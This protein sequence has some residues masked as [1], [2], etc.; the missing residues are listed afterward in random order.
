MILFLQIL[1]GLAAVALGIY[2]GG[3]RYTQSQE[4]IEARM[5]V[6]KP[7]RAKRHFMWLDSLKAHE[8]GS[9]RRRTRQHFQT[10]VARD[11]DEQ[12]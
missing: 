2:L 11:K 3:G 8:R 10:A 9:D 12:D 6:G 1:G 7:R 4:E 5:G